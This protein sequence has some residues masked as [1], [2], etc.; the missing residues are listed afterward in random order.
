MTDDN[1]PDPSDWRDDPAFDAELAAH[2]A[3]EARGEII[4]DGVV[5]DAERDFV[6]N[7]ALR[8]MLADARAMLT[9]CY[10]VN[11]QLAEALDAQTEFNAR[12][13]QQIETLQAAQNKIVETL[14]FLQS[15]LELFGN[16]QQ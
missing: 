5:Y 4:R 6:T 9:E 2:R 8:A 14:S 10:R 12:L 16:S 11:G 1:T 3:D 7:S 15:R 13:F